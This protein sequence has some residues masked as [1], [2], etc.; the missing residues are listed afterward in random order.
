MATPTRLLVTLQMRKSATAGKAVSAAAV[1]QQNGIAITP[2]I[3]AAA[4]KRF[5]MALSCLI[6]SSGAL[7]FQ[8]ETPALSI[9]WSHGPEESA[10]FSGS[11]CFVRRMISSE[12]VCNFSGSCCFVRHDLVRKVCNFSGSCRGPFDQYGTEIIDIGVGWTGSKQ[13]AQTLEEAG[14]IVVGKKRG[15][16]E[17]AHIC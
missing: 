1:T 7:S 13:I 2:S 4:A 9:W 12:K 15:G 3:R 8:T 16:I 6:D 14:G 10:T 17:A 11:C 5:A